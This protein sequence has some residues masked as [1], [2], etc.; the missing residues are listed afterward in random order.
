M[1]TPV[2]ADVAIEGIEATSVAVE[3]TAVVAAEEVVEVSHV[4]KRKG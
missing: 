1:A 4:M 2:L 3:A